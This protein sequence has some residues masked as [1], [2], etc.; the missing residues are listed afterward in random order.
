LAAANAPT[1]LLASQTVA[2]VSVH[3][4]P[5]YHEGSRQ[6]QDRFQARPLVDRMVEH[7][8]HATFTDE[9]RE[10]IDSGPHFNEV[11]RP[12]DPAG[13]RRDDADQS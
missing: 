5:M 11:L 1:T 12:G 9:D 6:L 2:E 4:I 10:F 13:P 3:A 7:I 8:V